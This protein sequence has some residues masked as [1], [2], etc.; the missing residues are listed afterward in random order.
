MLEY[1][2]SHVMA[3]QIDSTLRGKTVKTVLA[4]H[5]PHRFA[6][7]SGDPA[8]YQKKLEGKTVRSAWASGGLVEIFLDDIRLVFADG[9]N[10]RF[11]P[12]GEPFPEK[13]QLLLVFADGSALAASVQMY[14]GLWALQK[15]EILPFHE[16]GRKKPDPLS[17]EFGLSHFLSLDTEEGK[18]SVKGFLATGQRI[19]GLGN[20]VLQDIL[21]RA[22]LNPRRKT[23][24]LS[25][26]EWQDLFLSVKGKLREM[27]D[28]GGRDTEKDLFGNPGGYP[29]LLSSRTLG[30]PCPA[31]G[32]PIVREAFLGGNV[33]YCPVCQ[34][35]E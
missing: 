29:T 24:S 17:P 16:S 33:Y 20:G 23:G 28:A 18:I 10:L 22:R 9:T 34:K 27:T 30:S 35:R 2:E 31:C 11:L 26:S 19:P 3:N 6:W 8:E 21:F 14:G 7:F 32:A 12:A 13:H 4:A 1:P 5:S 25:D 15:G